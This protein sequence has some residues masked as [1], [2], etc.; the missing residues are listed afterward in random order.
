M[1]ECDNLY[2]SCSLS[3][4]TCGSPACQKNACTYADN[5]RSESQATGIGK[6]WRHS[7]VKCPSQL[8][9]VP[10]PPRPIWSHREASPLGTTSGKKKQ[11]TEIP[12]SSD[13]VRYV[14]I[15]PQIGNESKLMRKMV[16]SM[17]SQRT[18][19]FVIT[20]PSKRLQPIMTSL[21]VWKKVSAFIMVRLE[22]VNLDGLSKKQE[23]MHTL[24]IHAASSSV[25]T[26][27]SEILSSMSFV[28]ESTYP[29]CLGGLI[30]IQCEWNLKDQVPL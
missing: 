18:Y 25:A 28:V 23:Q 19:T 29:T 3:P 7:P 22:P 27:V 15:V 26:G 2:G 13:N 20:G 24:R 9:S 11:E 14:G 4:E 1:Q 16:N 12:S 10:S 21:S 5:L 30:D 17:W 6:Y 8:P